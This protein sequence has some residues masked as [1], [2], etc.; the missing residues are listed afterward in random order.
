MFIFSLFITIIVCFALL[1]AVVVV[2]KLPDL[3]R[4]RE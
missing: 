3:V 2:R 4:M 1:L